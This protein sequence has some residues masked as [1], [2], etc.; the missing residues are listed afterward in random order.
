MTGARRRPQAG[1]GAARDDGLLH[2][3]AQAYARAG[4]CAMD[5]LSLFEHLADERVVS[6]DALAQRSPV[7][8]AGQQ[9]S[10]LQRKLRW[11]QQTLKHL[12]LLERDPARRGVWRLT[13]EGKRQFVRPAPRKILLGFSTD[14]GIALWASAEDAFS[15]IDVPLCLALASPPYPIAKG[16]AYGRAP[17]A[18]YV[19]FICKLTEPVVRNMV[20][21]GSLVLNV[22]ND[23]FEPEQPARST[24]VERL[25]IALVDR[26][27]LHLVDR[28]PWV[29]LSKPPGP[30]R[31]AS[32]D[33]THLNS[34][35]EPCYWFTTDPHRL[36][37]DNRRVLLAHTKRQQ[38]LIHAGGEQR[39]R[40]FSDGA[41]TL[42]PGRSFAND[43]PGK[44]ARN[45]LNFGH[46][47]AGQQ[48]YKR[49]ARELAL[50]VHGAPF[51]EAMIRFLVEFMTEPGDMVADFCAGSQTTAAVCEELGRPWITTEIIGEYIRGGAE[52]VKHRPGFELHDDLLD[53]LM[54]RG[55]HPT[56]EGQQPLQFVQP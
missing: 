13:G 33:R 14:L 52:R 43:T 37:S 2:L 45:V 25:V 18:A 50:P 34:G 12:G 24:Y 7:G 54:R 17:L 30:V 31:Y 27:G 23:V 47:C 3:V 40:S 46:A 41:Y 49:A 8:R 9:H 15:T 11:H 4:G 28:L 29:N 19:D 32:L 48:A 5:N 55:S 44:I 20:P 1:D 16:R 26:L 6:R 56:M 22:S 35:W 38:Q 36:R 53:G 39:Q 42:R 51:P 21:G 10:L